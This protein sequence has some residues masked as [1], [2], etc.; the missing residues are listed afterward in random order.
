MFQDASDKGYPRAKI[1]LAECYSQGKGGVKQDYD[2]AFK[3]LNEAYETEPNNPALLEKLAIAYARGNGTP[4]EPGKAFTLMEQAAELGW[5][6]A[7][8]N[9]GA[10]YMEGMG[11]E[12]D[13]QKAAAMYKR[14]ADQQ[15]LPCTFYYA[16][17][18]ENG[19]GVHRDEAGAFAAMQQVADGGFVPPW[20]T[21]VR[22]I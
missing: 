3:L 22:T 15:D 12:K 2:R 6:S 10:Y 16:L 7:Y 19:A 11:T 1:W 8:K 20:A 14:G 4:P 5:V 21:W 17:C 18:L 13:P 9:L